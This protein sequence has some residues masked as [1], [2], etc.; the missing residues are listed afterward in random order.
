LRRRRTYP[1]LLPVMLLDSIFFDASLHLESLK[2]H[3]SR[4][5]LM[6]L[7]HFPLIADLRLPLEGSH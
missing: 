5:A 7:D 1:R 4:T 3:R 6:A 2:L